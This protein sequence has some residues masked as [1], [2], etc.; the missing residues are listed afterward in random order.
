MR[1]KGSDRDDFDVELFR[2]MGVNGRASAATLD[3]R[4]GD[5]GG[6]FMKHPPW[7][8]LIGPRSTLLDW[9][10]SCSGVFFI[11]SP[12]DS[13]LSV[14]WRLLGVVSRARLGRASATAES[15]LELFLT[16]ES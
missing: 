12:E 10:S 13:R 14:G 8:L 2:C 4:S 9:R 11:V 5:M 15:V 7:L 1:W 6:S 16:G 3:S